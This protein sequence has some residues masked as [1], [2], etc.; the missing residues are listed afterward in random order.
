MIN[1]ITFASL[2]FA[3]TPQ[4]CR[5]AQN[6]KPLRRANQGCSGTITCSLWRQQPTFT[7]HSLPV[8]RRTH[9]RREFGQLCA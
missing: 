2:L 5:Q 6:E 8:S 3:S 7:P 9:S 1:F 4:Y